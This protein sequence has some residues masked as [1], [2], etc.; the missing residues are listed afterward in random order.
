MPC[1][2]VAATHLHTSA[3]RSSSVATTTLSTLVAFIA[4]IQVRMIIGLPA[5]STSGLPGKREDL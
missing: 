5:M 4:C 3:M 2:G 1:G